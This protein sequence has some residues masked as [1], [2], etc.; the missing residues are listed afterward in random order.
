VQS[1]ADINV[2]IL[3]VCEIRDSQDGSNEDLSL[4][5]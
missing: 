1:L 3:W 2:Y 5:G 4:M